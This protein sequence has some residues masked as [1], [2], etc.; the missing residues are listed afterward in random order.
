MKFHELVDDI[1]N[2]LER[3]NKDH[4]RKKK[5]EGNTPTNLAQASHF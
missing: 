1:V 2:T 4:V 3:E 5:K